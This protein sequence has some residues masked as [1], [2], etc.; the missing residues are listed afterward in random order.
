MDTFRL[1]ATTSLG[2]GRGHSAR[3]VHVGP[4][5]GRGRYARDAPA[6]LWLALLTAA[7]LATTPALSTAALL[8]ALHFAAAALLPATAAF[9][10]A[11]VAGLL[12]GVRNDGPPVVVGR[13]GVHGV[14]R[15]VVGVR[16]RQPVVVVSPAAAP[17]L[18]APLAAAATT[19]ASAA[20]LLSAR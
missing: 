10:A 5:V 3:H 16:W 1:C 13:I 9:L 7:A 19:T 14:A 18:P 20:P 15:F 4:F 8:T 6:A 2:L 12:V 11:C 17:R